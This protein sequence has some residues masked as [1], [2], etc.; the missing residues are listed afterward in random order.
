MTDEP[1]LDLDLTGALVRP[2][3]ITNGQDLPSDEQFS[4]TTL[5]M[6]TEDAPGS[7]IL[8]PESQ[9]ILDLCAGGYL[10]VV[11]VA[12]HTGLPL[13]VVRIVLAQLAERRLINTRAA[14]PLAQRTDRKLLE[15]VLNGLKDRFGA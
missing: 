14:V 1:D 5:V 12:G 8:A 2:Y 7:R 6:A 11:E 15:D 9:H 13:G 4:M 3:V 10:S